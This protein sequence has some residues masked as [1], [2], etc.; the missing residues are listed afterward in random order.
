MWHICVK[1]H[2]RS[3]RQRAKRGEGLTIW[4]RA[5]RWWVSPLSSDSLTHIKTDRHAGIQADLSIHHSN[6]TSPAAWGFLFSYLQLATCCATVCCEIIHLMAH[7]VWWTSQHLLYMGHIIYGCLY[8]WH[9]IGRWS[10]RKINS[11][12][13]Y[14]FNSEYYRDIRESVQIN[15]SCSS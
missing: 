1:S 11:Q 8:M 7:R 10:E 3:E 9:I 6:S 5:R 4:F 13:M 15:L 14:R 12:I 2:G